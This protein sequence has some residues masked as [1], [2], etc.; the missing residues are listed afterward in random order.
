METAEQAVA[1]LCALAGESPFPASFDSREGW[2][3]TILTAYDWINLGAHLDARFPQTAHGG[4]GTAEE[5]R[6]LL[7]SSVA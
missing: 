3:A 1:A 7:A 4:H 6:D 5:A 2:N